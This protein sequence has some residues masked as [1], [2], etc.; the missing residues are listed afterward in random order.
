MHCMRRRLMAQA[1][2]SA[3]CGHLFRDGQINRRHSE[4]RSDAA[5]SVSLWRCRAETGRQRREVA[6]PFGLA[7]ALV[8]FHLVWKFTW[9]FSVLCRRYVLQ[10]RHVHMDVLMSR[11][12]L[13]LA[14]F[15]RLENSL[16][17]ETDARERRCRDPDAQKAQSSY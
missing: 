13:C 8:L 17:I 2:S 10:E 16:T 1:T 6:T 3:D 4:E 7:M 15:S 11:S 5:T 9:P 12:E 14:E